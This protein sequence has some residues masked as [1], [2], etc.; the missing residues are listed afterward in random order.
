MLQKKIA[1][2]DDAPPTKIDSAMFKRS[3]FKKVEEESQKAVS[4]LG[5]PTAQSR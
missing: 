2:L 3:P 5:G 4:D 1:E